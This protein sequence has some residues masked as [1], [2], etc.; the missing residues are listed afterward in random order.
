MPSRQTKTISIDPAILRR[1][2]FAALKDGKTVREITEEV[3]LA[4]LDEFERE[5]KYEIL[6]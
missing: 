2:K 6:L 3:I 4:W 5:H 1:L